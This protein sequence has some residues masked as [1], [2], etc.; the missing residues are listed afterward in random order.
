MHVSINFELKPF[1]LVRA[2]PVVVHAPHHLRGFVPVRADGAAPVRR[3]AVEF[4]LR[5]HPL[6]QPKVD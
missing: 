5:A 6:G 3:D 4:L 1:Q 2:L